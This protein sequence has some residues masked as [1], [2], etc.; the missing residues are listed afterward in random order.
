MRQK[1]DRKRKGGEEIM[2]YR[3][4]GGECNRGVER[5]KQSGGERKRGRR[6][7]EGESQK[8]KKSWCNRM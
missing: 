2:K 5:E 7:R 4:R 6:T 8:E 3:E 1:R